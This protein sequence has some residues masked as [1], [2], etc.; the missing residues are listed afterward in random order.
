[1]DVALPW[2]GSFYFRRVLEITPSFSGVSVLSGKD[3]PSKPI[4]SHSIGIQNCLLEKTG[5]G[6]GLF[7]DRLEAIC[8]G[9]KWT[10]HELAVASGGSG[11]EAG[12]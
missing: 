5:S 2:G 10:R 7:G 11:P 3:W 6:E 9:R 1:M 4:E 8:L 12:K